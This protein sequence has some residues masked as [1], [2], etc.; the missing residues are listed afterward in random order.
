MACDKSLLVLLRVH[1]V[2]F[3]QNMQR[4]ILWSSRLMSSRSQFRLC[5]ARS[6]MTMLNYLSQSGNWR[7]APAPPLWR[8]H[9]WVHQVHCISFG[10]PPWDH[11]PSVRILYW[12]WNHQAELQ[13]RLSASPRGREDHKGTPLRFVVRTT[14]DI[15]QRS[16]EWMRV[17]PNLLHWLLEQGIKLFIKG[18][19]IGGVSVDLN[20]V[21]VAHHLKN[22]PEQS[23]RNT[24]PQWSCA[25]AESLLEESFSI[26]LENAAAPYRS[27]YHTRPP[28]SFADLKDPQVFELSFFHRKRS[29]VQRLG[30]R[31]WWGSCPRPQFRKNLLHSLNPPCVV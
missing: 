8:V 27:F 18:F 21:I 23:E 11:Q 25:S 1:S 26:L 24:F 15:H 22:A 10:F 20:E 19:G 13:P 28:T 30:G 5:L 4:I 14:L 6:T 17:R 9:S 29:W 16:N 12:R 3:R 7:I 31:R 2:L